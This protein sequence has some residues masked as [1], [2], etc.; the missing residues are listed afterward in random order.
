MAGKNRGRG[1]ER[2]M[3]G[4]EI[5][6]K[7]LKLCISDWFYNHKLLTF[8][9]IVAFLLTIWLWPV[10]I[11]DKDPADVEEIYF[12]DGNTGRSV[13]ITGPGEIETLVESFR[14]VPLRRMFDLSFLIPRDGI[15]LLVSIKLKSTG[16]SYGFDLKSN[17]MVEKL[18]YYQSYWGEYPYEYYKSLC[19]EK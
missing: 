7:E 15:G 6:W 17:Q 1:S 4:R 19:I 11:F 14:Q 16:E 5:D 12:F 2:V 10:W 3:N 13:S 18:F 8:L 9:L